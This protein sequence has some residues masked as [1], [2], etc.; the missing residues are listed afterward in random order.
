MVEPIQWRVKKLE[1]ENYRTINILDNII[2]EL[3]ELKEQHKKL[4]HEVYVHVGSDKDTAHE[5]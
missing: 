1:D 4:K 5:F 3:H 2:K